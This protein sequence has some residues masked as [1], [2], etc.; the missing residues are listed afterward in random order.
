MFSNETI[1]IIGA[2]S[3][4]ALFL[5]NVA[6]MD[7][8]LYRPDGQGN[9]KF[10]LSVL[11]DYIIAPFQYGTLKFDTIWGNYDHL[12]LNEQIDLL[13]LNWVA[14]TGAGLSLAGLIVFFKWVL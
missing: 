12:K 14:M 9:D 5:Y 4:F 1:L 2:V 6:T 10:T 7:G 13:Q 8:I 3:G 11:K